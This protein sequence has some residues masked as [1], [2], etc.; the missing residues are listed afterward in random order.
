MACGAEE[1]KDFFGLWNQGFPG[2]AHAA[3]VWSYSMEVFLVAYREPGCI[4]FLPREN[5][6]RGFYRPASVLAR[7]MGE[8]NARRLAPG[9][10]G[11][12]GGG[13]KRGLN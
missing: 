5:R 11:G 13:G 6:N 3:G 2:P 12:G 8:L 1:F 9:G 10:G 7:S 4:E